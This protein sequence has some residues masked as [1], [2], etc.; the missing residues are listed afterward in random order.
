MDET[1]ETT[2]VRHV[3]NECVIDCDSH[4]RGLCTLETVRIN[5]RIVA[6]TGPRPPVCLAACTM[7]W[8]VLYTTP[9][10]VC[11]LSTATMLLP[12]TVMD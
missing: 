1:T 8:V 10:V 3:M 2:A 11:R 12:Y 5:G 9:R 6:P 7:E 4:L